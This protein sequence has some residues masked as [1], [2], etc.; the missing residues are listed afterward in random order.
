MERREQSE[1]VRPHH[2]SRAHLETMY[3]ICEPGR[4]K[5]IIKKY[6]KEM[7]DKIQFHMNLDKEL[8]NIRI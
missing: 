8:L 1:A 6:T 7:K 3:V 2:V 4:V 5:M